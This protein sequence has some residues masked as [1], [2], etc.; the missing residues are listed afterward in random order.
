MAPMKALGVELAPTGSWHCEIKFDGYRAIAVVNAGKVELWSRN[1]KSMAHDYPMVVAALRKLPCHSAVLDGEIVALDSG[2]RSRFQLLQNRNRAGD[3]PIIVFYLFDLLHLDGKA[4]TALPWE[5]RRRQLES[6]ARKPPPPLQVSPVFDVP[7]ATLLNVARRQGLEG[8][9]A[10]RPGS[11]YAADRRNGAWIKCKVRAEQE[12]VIGGFTAPRG[13]RQHFGAILVGYYKGQN[14][15]YAGKVGT[16]FDRAGLES[17]HEKFIRR[18]Q[19]ECPF[20]NLPIPGK[21]RFG[22]GMTGSEMKRVTWLK[23]G[24]VA[25]IKFAEWTQDGLLRQ[26]VF[27]GLR[28]DKAAKNVHREAGPV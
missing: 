1:H 23:P 17:L 26:P 7:P 12:L 4:L 5:E 3:R 14:L 8:V 22:Q 25:Q 13:S 6:L 10:K 27:L 24:L 18:G 28:S 2:G 21:P 9:V 19:V 20:A 15:L 11:A 16:G